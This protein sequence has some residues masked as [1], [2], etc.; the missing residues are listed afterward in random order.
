MG[1]DNRYEGRL[2]TFIVAK[3]SSEPAALEFFQQGVGMVLGL[4]IIL[5]NAVEAMTGFGSTVVTPALGSSLVPIKEL[6]P[7]ILPLNL[8]LSSY[9]IASN[10]RNLDWRLLWRRLVP[11]ALIG[12]P[13]GMAIYLVANSQ[14]VAGIFGIF[15]FVLSL[16]NI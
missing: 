5:A 11:F 15:V 1:Y 3:G 16:A 8:V 2:G 14:V 12:L 10:W 6:V 7:L 9:L 13:V 4:I